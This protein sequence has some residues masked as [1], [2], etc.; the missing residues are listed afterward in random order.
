[1][2]DKQSKDTIRILVA[3][4]SPTQAEQMKYLLEGQ[5]Y[6]VTIAVNGR[7]A[8]A[9]ARQDKPALIISDV[10]MPELDGYEFCR[11]VK[12]DATM[13]AIPVILVTSLSSPHDVVKGLECGA[14]SFLRKPYNENHLLARIEQVLTNHDL[15]EE[16]RMRAGIEIV[17]SGQRHFI[18]AERQQILDLLIST[19]EEA[20]R[21]NEE[22]STANRQLEMRNREVERANQF[23]DE[24]LSMMSHE[25]RTPLNAILGFS[26]LLLDG[27]F[28]P[29][30]GKP[31]Q[32]V[33][34]IH[35]SGRHLLRLTNDILDVSRIEAGRME[36][37]VETVSLQTVVSEVLESLRPLSEKKSQNLG[38]KMDGKL[39]VRADPTRIRQVLTN[40]VGNAIKFTPTGG[41]IEV[42]AHLTGDNVRINVEDDGPGIPAHEREH[43][44]QAFY[45]LKREGETEGTGL[46]LSIS[47]RLVEMHGGRLDVE[48]R[49]GTGSCFF[50][51]L[52]S[53][54]T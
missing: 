5:G 18:T 31:Q 1:M 52:P 10:V 4:D 36:L 25:V 54:A 39:T 37:V 34:H 26:E 9:L 22:L 33:D 43:I 14:D 3:E 30:A 11:E 8:L 42:R 46:G 53:V 17:L 47:H 49:S 40:L 12:S 21:I 51:T 16:G 15:R 19:Y 24:F 38:Q 20:V 44:F 29:L 28:G 6:P 50:F 23:K 2:T 41:S 13:K 48:S 32:Y 45:R 7:R 27:R 35:N